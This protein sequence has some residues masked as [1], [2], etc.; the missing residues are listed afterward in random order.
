MP[1]RRAFGAA[2]VDEN[3]GQNAVCQAQ[4]ESRYGAVQRMRRVR[5]IMSD[6]KYKNRARQSKIR[7]SLHDLLQMRKQMQ[8]K[9]DHDP[10][11][12]EK[13]GKIGRGGA[14]RYLTRVRSGGLDL[15]YF[16]AFYSS[17]DFKFSWHY[18]FSLNSA[19][20]RLTLAII[21]GKFIKFAKNSALKTPQTSMR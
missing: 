8:A 1:H 15:A 6:A 13:S 20:C 18:I 10:R 9:G 5:E 2:A 7:R 21:S 19:I 3:L 16:I 11:Q 12:G 4:I 17:K 14:Q